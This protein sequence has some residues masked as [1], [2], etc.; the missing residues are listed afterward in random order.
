[1]RTRDEVLAFIAEYM[2]ENSWAPSYREIGKAVGVSSTSTVK[3][4][5]DRLDFDG[6]IRFGH[7]PRKIAVTDKGMA[8]IAE[9][10]ASHGDSRSRA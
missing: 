1:M 10:E 5:I 6:L 3:E 9:L 8:R 7:G 4:H 2:R